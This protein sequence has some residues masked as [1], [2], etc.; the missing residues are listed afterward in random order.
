MAKQNE[1]VAL[2][3]EQLA[4][5]G[6]ISSRAMF[7]G[8]SIY[9]DGLIFAI[10]VDE[11]LYFKVDSLSIERY[12]RLGLGPFTY[13]SKDGKAMHMAYYTPPEEAMDDRAVLLDWAREALGVALRAQAVKQEKASRPKKGKKA[14][15]AEE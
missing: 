11:V 14:A 1:F 10:V 7:G 13:K 15:V 2:L 12:T 4:P 9:C 8:W 5:L 3:C 6:S